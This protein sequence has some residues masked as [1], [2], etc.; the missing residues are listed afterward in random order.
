M[1]TGSHI[2]DI[3]LWIARSKPVQVTATITNN[4]APV[5]INDIV[6]I[7][8]A[9]G[10]IASV[11]TVGSAISFFEHHTFVCEEGVLRYEYGKVIVGG[12][13]QTNLGAL[14][15]KR[16]SNRRCRGF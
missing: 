10:K 16:L 1:D 4:G 15:G 6:G 9:D 5:E 12:V 14:S 2:V 3:T 7:Q 8:F 11:V 13:S